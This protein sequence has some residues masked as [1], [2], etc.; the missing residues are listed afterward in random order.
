MKR[1]VVPL[2]SLRYVASL[3]LVML[4]FYALIYAPHE[5]VGAAASVLEFYLE[6]TALAS[7]ALLR[8]FG[9]LVQLDGTQ[10]SGRFSF[11][12]VLDCAALD[13]QALFAASVLAYPAPWWARVVGVCVGAFGIFL[14]NVA[15]LVGLYFAGAHS[16]ELFH[17]LHEEVLVFVLVALVC[18][19]F[20]LW[21]RW[22][23]GVTPL[24]SAREGRSSERF[25]AKGGA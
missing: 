3:A 1:S 5:G 22:A 15:R 23:G 24:S 11:V 10:V 12:V 14:L 2:A 18:G 9:E 13:A 16:L 6:A 7:A 4:G 8:V 17:L 21:L 20:L 19:G 25:G